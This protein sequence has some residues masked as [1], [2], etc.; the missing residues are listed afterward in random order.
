MNSTEY[1]PETE[2]LLGIPF[3]EDYSLTTLI[4]GKYFLPMAAFWVLTIC[5]ICNPSLIVL[6][7]QIIKWTFNCCSEYAKIIN[8]NC[9]PNNT[10][11]TSQSRSLNILGRRPST[12]STRSRL[13]RIPNIFSRN[14][15]SGR[16]TLGRRPSAYSIRSGLGGRPRTYNIRSSQDRSPSILDSDLYEMSTYPNTLGRQRTYN[17]VIKFNNTTSTPPH[18]YVTI[19]TNDNRY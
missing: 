13:S 11:S 1:V 9:K 14:S 3:T 18:H 8:K 4:F 10:S 6:F 12:H 19:Y 7:F 16:N 15:N 5:C 2:K 17:P